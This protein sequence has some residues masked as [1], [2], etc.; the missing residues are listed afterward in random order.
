MSYILTITILLNLIF[1]HLITVIVAFI[2]ALVSFIVLSLILFIY[3]RIISVEQNKNKVL[4]D[5]LNFR[6]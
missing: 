6:R 5:L 2:I 4:Y 1:I 3:Y